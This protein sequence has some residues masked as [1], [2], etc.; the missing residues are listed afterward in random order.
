MDLKATP[1]TLFGYFG[2]S[3]ESYFYLSRIVNIFLCC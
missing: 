2:M 3:W 1:M